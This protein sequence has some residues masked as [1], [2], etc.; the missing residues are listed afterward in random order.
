[1]SHSFILPLQELFSEVMNN[2]VTVFRS[3][4]E[5]ASDQAAGIA[6]V[7]KSQGIEP[8]ILDDSAPGVPEGAWEVQVAAADAARADAALASVPPPKPDGSHDMDLVTVY[9]SGDGSSEGDVEA[10][11][12]RNLLDAAGIEA[13]LIGGRVPFPNLT[14]E[15]K[16][17]KDQLEAARQVIAEALASGPAG[18]E[19]GEAE[20]ESS[21]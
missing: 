12:V 15:V 6:E 3:A 13:V 16:V 5:D 1:L 7:L 2:L 8:T 19:Q 10:L 9:S 20:S 21:S 17:P 18:A 4:D 14:Q 11:T